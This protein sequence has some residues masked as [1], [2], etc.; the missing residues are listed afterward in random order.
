MGLVTAQNPCSFSRPRPPPAMSQLNKPNCVWT[1]GRFRSEPARVLI[2]QWRYEAASRGR[3]V[4][5]HVVGG[6]VLAEATL[7]VGD[8]GWRVARALRQHL[9]ECGPS[10]LPD[11]LAMLEGLEIAC[12]TLP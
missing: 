4:E 6:I 2:A 7:R 3:L 11:M 12:T 8:A 10:I 5:S 1:S 9:Q